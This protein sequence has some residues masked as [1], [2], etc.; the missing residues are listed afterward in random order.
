M[1]NP[2]CSWVRDRLPLLAGDE[3]LG[4]DRR[5]VERH[6]IGCPKC[7]QH[8]HSLDQ[9]LAVLHAASAQS[10]ARSEA[11]SLW[12]ELAR[13]IRQSHRAAPAPL[14][15]WPRL[16]FRPALAGLIVVLLLVALAVATGSR[17][18]A[19]RQLANALNKGAISIVQPT[20][21]QGPIAPSD[22]PPASGLDPAKTAADPAPV[23]ENLPAPASK[24][25]Y[26]LERGTPMGTE[27]REEKQRTY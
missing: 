25:D 5:R 12:P 17:K 23:A 3:L 14:W 24:L 21:D 22:D 26:Y 2:R 15:T 13:Q 9:A 1:A 7:R 18:Q 19:D 6:L 10:P 8:H 4:S 20:P 11:P 16:G 27:T